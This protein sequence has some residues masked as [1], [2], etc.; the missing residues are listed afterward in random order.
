[1]PDIDILVIDDDAN[2]C[3]LLRLYLEKEGYK[4]ECAYQGTQG[5]ALAEA[6]KPRLIILDIM[7]PGM[8]GW[9]VCKE[10]R[11]SSDVPILM[12][13]AK[14]E[15]FDK[16][17]GLELGADDYMVKPFEP[18]ELLARVKALLRRSGTGL[19]DTNGNPKQELK[20]DH[21]KISL[22]DYTV[23]YFDK[24]IELPPKE[25][26]LLFFL[27]DH[28]NTV[29]TREQLLEQVWGFEYFGD[30]RTVDVHVKRLRE[31]F[32]PDA[33]VNWAIKT[34]WGVGYKFEVK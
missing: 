31:K 23:H 25:M 30:S 34:V 15:T 27:A 14:G 11:K 13:S 6:R 1:M 17:L 22:K 5:V 29:F 2:I 26:E 9:D 21:L 32:P 18:Q 33:G 24:T 3:Q 19:T 28:K 16:V 12:L 7:L 20:F 4:V 10:I 8:D